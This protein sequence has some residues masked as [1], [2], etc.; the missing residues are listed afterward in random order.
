M[1]Q[2]ARE[3]DRLS[4]AEKQRRRSLLIS[5]VYGGDAAAFY[6]DLEARP[7]YIGRALLHIDRIIGAEAKPEAPSKPRKVE[8]PRQAPKRETKPKTKIKTKAQPQKKARPMVEKAGRVE[9]EKPVKPHVPSFNKWWGVS[10]DEL[11]RIPGIG[12]KTVAA[13]RRAGYEDVA[14]VYRDSV[15]GW[16]SLAAVNGIGP[17]TAKTLFREIESRVPTKDQ[18][19]AKPEKTVQPLKGGPSPL[20][21]IDRIE[22]GPRGGWEVWVRNPD[23]RGYGYK[24]FDTFEEALKYAQRGEGGYHDISEGDSEARWTPIPPPPTLPAHLKEFRDSRLF[25]T[26]ISEKPIYVAGRGW[27]FEKRYRG[28]G[29]MRTRFT[30]DELQEEYEAGQRRLAE[31]QRMEKQSRTL[32]RPRDAKG[33]RY[34]EK[35]VKPYTI[36]GELASTSPYGE[37]YARVRVEGDTVEIEGMDPGHVSLTRVRF[38]NDERLLPDGEYAIESADTYY[39]SPLSHPTKVVWDAPNHTLRFLKGDYES[40][41]KLEP[42]TEIGAPDIPTPKLWYDAGFNVKLDTLLQVT[43]K[44][45]DEFSK[46]KVVVATR[47]GEGREPAVMFEWRRSEGQTPVREIHEPGIY[48]DVRDVRLTD[49]DRHVAAVYDPQYLLGILRRMKRMGFTTL[50]FE[51]RDD[52]PLHIKAEAADAEVEFWEAPLIGVE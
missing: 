11:K 42:P 17:E 6:R 47:D 52:M 2:V 40:S 3:W 15:S 51:L 4:K 21:Y 27:L 16:G 50:D 43:K 44:A 32:E 20:F 24:R 8:K 28:P 9:P 18:L 5:R 1:S 30:L 34:W 46:L 10:L 7:R 39:R 14:Q 38:P 35:T 45:V 25:K 31:K 13:L 41:F 48:G 12:P 37:T 26:L 22:E 49:D 29:D 23:G 33:R 19:K 36:L